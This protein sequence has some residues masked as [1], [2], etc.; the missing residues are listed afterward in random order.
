MIRARRT[1]VTRAHA[2]VNLDLRVLG[3]RSDGY[4][5][6]RTVF[7]TIEL[8]DVLVFAESRGGISLKSRTAS[9]P[10]DDTNF[11]WSAA[12]AHRTALG[13]SRH[14]GSHRIEDVHAVLDASVVCHLAVVT[15][16]GPLVLPTAPRRVRRQP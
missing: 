7:Q 2:K 6:L 14:R 11:V 4:H 3:T 8:H 1:L 5:E 15:R 9:V 16:D 12:A 10:V 13:R